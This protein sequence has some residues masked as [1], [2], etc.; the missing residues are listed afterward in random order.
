MAAG[1]I[2]VSTAVGGVEDV[3]EGGRWGRLVRSREPAAFAAALEDALTAAF[4]G[5]DAP[6][7]RNDESGRREYARRRYGVVRLVDDHA[8]LY[9]R[10]LGEKGLL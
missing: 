10:L 1:C 7:E 3:L 5:Y 2:P 4:E 9:R 8:A 6:E